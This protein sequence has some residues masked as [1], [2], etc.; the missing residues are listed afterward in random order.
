[1]CLPLQTADCRLQRAQGRSAALQ[2]NPN[3]SLHPGSDCTNAR[4]HHPRHPP[5]AHTA[6]ATVTCANAHRFINRSKKSSTSGPDK[7][8]YTAAGGCSMHMTVSLGQPAR[9]GLRGQA[10]GGVLW[11]ER[12]G[13]AGRA[14][15]EP[16]CLPPPLPRTPAS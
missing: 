10:H 4:V 8:V 3:P 11:C 2:M 7:F 15:H 6:C 5:Y 16:P 12:T 1:V 9:P 13:L 14:H